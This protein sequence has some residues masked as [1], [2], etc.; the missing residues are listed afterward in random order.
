MAQRIQVPK[1]EDITHKEEANWILIQAEEG[2]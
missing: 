2:L 1:K